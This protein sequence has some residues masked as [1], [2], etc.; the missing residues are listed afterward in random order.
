MKKYVADY[1]N[2]VAWLIALLGI[3]G[4]LYPQYFLNLPPCVLCWYQRIFMYP[5]FFILTV[6]IILRDHNLP[7]YILPLS[8]IGGVIA[9]YHNL[10][11]SHILSETLSPCS[12]GASCIDPKT[13]QMGPISI[14]MVSL[15]GF[16]VIT[17]IMIINYK[18]YE[19]R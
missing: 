13:Q 15:I 3:V 6:G 8:V 11:Y 18:K 7:K 12:I 16:I 19:S 1:G 17:I 5:M 9:I 10:L 2:Y 4:S 14:P